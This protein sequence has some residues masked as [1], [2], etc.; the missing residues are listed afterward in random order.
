MRSMARLAAYLLGA[1]IALA[2]TATLRTVADTACTLKNRI[3]PAEPAKHRSLA[4]ARDCQNQ[5]LMALFRP[6]TDGRPAATLEGH[7]VMPR[8]KSKITS[9]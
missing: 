9:T 4:D 5:Y 7:R 8:S 3:H 6:Q 1:A 2:E